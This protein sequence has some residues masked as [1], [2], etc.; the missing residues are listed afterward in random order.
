MSLQATR[1][2]MLRKA[3]AEEIRRYAAE[4]KAEHKHRRRCASCG[5]P[6]TPINRFHFF[7]RPDCRRAWYRGQFRP[8]KRD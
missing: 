3:V 7:D 8:R 1:D 4:H 2:A 5:K 6:F